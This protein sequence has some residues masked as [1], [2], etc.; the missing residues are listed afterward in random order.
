MVD[1]PQFHVFEAWGIVRFGD[2]LDAARLQPGLSVFVQAA[3]FDP[4]FH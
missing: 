3:Q 1:L 2:G 4:V